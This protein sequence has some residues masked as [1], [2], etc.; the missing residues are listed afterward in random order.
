MPV[1]CHASGKTGKQ[2][3]VKGKQGVNETIFPHISHSLS[4]PRQTSPV[5]VMLLHSRLCPSFH[6][7]LFASQYLLIWM[8]LDLG[9]LDPFYPAPGG[10]RVSS[11]APRG[12][13]PPVSRQP[14]VCSS[15]STPGS[16]GRSVGLRRFSVAAELFLS[17]SR[18]GPN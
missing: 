17:D 13:F 2:H 7:F 8:P 3:H 4:P 12:P 11:A 15:V 1:L 18:G 5:D 14:S 6:N 10:P 16:F 9:C